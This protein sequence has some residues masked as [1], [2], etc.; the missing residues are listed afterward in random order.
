MHS[1]KRW[2]PAALLLLLGSCGTEEKETRVADY[3]KVVETFYHQYGFKPEG[4]QQ[5][6]FAKKR[7]GWFVHVVDPLK[8]A[9]L[10]DFLY[11]PA[12]STAPR[13]LSGFSAPEGGL[14]TDRAIES[15]LRGN[16]TG[17]TYYGYERCRY[18]G[19]EE[20]DR[21][22]IRTYGDRKQPGDTLLEGLGRAFSHY[23]DRFLDHY[24]TPDRPGL[25][26]LQ[27]GLAPLERPSQQRADSAL[28]YYRKALAAFGKLR[29]RN[30]SYTTLVGNMAMKV[31][32]DGM[33]V[34]QRLSVNGYAQ[35]AASILNEVKADDNIR[36][37]AHNYLDACAPNSILFTYGDNDTYAIWYL[38]QKEG[39]RKDVTVINASLAG[40]PIYVDA[41][42]REGKVR[43]D[44]RP[45][46]YGRRDF[47]Y[48]VQI[49]E[50]ARGTEAVPQF[51]AGFNDR[52]SS[53]LPASSGTPEPMTYTASSLVLPVDAARFG[54]AT[55]T[56]VSAGML[57]WT[58]NRYITLDQVLMLNVIQRNIHERPIYFSFPDS[59]HGD[60]LMPAGTVY[61]LVPAG[62]NSEAIAQAGAERS[63]QLLKDRFQP[64]AASPAGKLAVPDRAGALPLNA[65][66]P[67]I[68]HYVRRQDTAT[69]KALVAEWRQ[70]Q[71]QSTGGA[72]N[73]LEVGLALASVGERES[74][75]P[76]M[77]SALIAMRESVQRPSAL[78]LRVGADDL[79][80][81]HDRVAEA[82]ER[83]GLSKTEIDSFLKEV[84]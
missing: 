69:V 4:Y 10:R 15:A 68:M 9:V 76:L 52:S 64:L 46:L 38:Q 27:K 57:K 16:S 5:L 80:N 20:W 53:P 56:A 29:E 44:L 47:S 51:I 67:L 28:Y 48:A 62:D 84:R 6:R 39:V 33:H 58:L 21:D 3:P 72:Y 30:P 43:F 55:Q 26:P 2:A 36:R 7:E 75:L 1:L 8:G 77:K 11:W 24:E 61:Q 66:E 14:E 71:T 25:H 18:Y 60:Q 42:R 12:D 41:L 83:Y 32:N 49:P 22:M 37:F 74:G 79:K 78:G 54:Q 81:Y 19:Y 23:A 13:T 35:E 82:L 34:W 50:G 73:G 59:F 31:F 45:E 63:R 70:K 40:L 65:Y 17:Y